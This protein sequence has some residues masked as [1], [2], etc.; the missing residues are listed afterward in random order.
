MTRILVTGAGGFVGRA[1]VRR[2]QAEGREVRGTVRRKID[3]GPGIETRVV[4]DLA[5]DCRRDWFF[6]DIDAVV[7][8]AARVHRMNES[9]TGELDA[10]L[11]DNTETTRLLAEAASAAGVRRLVFLSSIKAGG[12]ETLVPYTED[13]PPK[14]EDAYGISKWRAE[15]ELAEISAKTGLETVILRPPLV[16]GPGVGANFRAL[17][18]ITDSPLPLPIGGLDGNR[19]SLIYCANLTDAIGRALEHPDAAGKTF[20]VRD[21]EDVS[22]AGLARRLRAALGRPARIVPVP[23]ALLKT[24]AG[25]AGRNTV[26]RRLAG[27][28]CVDDSRIRRDLDWQPPFTLD[29]G[30]AATAAWYRAM[31]AARR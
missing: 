23:V 28:L 7:H 4:A 24:M 12:E 8:L 10:Y 2:L 30:L 14:P 13:T 3:L 20:M 6:Q 16:Y 21:G 25:V 15:Q 22:T 29:Q 5:D 19:R 26:I 27:S 9:G 17:L 18:R 31:R 11:R 1:L